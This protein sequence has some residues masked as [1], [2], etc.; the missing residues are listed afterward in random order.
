MNLFKNLIHYTPKENLTELLKRIRRYCGK[1]NDDSP[2]IWGLGLLDG[3]S[4]EKSQWIERQKTNYTEIDFTDVEFYDEDNLWDIEVYL[5]GKIEGTEFSKNEM[6]HKDRA[7]LNGIIRKTKPKTIVEIGVSAGGS[8]CVI[9]NAIRDMENS[10]LYS[11]DY[12]TIWYRDNGQDNG[13]KTGFLVNKIVPEYVSKWE[14]YTGGVPCKYF[15]EHLPNEG[16]DI[17]FIDTA[18]FNPGEHLN[19]LEILPFM[20]KNGII[21]YHDTA[22]HSLSNPNGTTNLVSINT[23]NGKRILLDSNQTMGL[24]NIGAII[25]T[26]NMETKLFSLFSNLS[27]PWYCNITDDDFVEMYKYFSK[28]YSNDL[29][30]I[31]IYYCYFYMNGGLQ[32]KI[33]AAQIAEKETTN[34]K[35]EVINYNNL[36]NESIN[37]ARI[38]H[39]HFNDKFANPTIS[40]INKHFPKDEHLHLVYR[41]FDYV[42]TA[43]EFPSGKNVFEIKYEMINPD[44]LRNKKL[45][46]HSL[47]H[48]ENVKLLY[49]N[50]NL[51]NN[52]YWM[53]WGGDL[54]NAP[55]DIYNEYVR[56]NIYGIG[57]FCD[58]EITREKYG[59]NHKYFNTNLVYPPMGRNEIIRVTVK[60]I[61]KKRNIVIQINNSAD[62]TTIEMLDILSKFKNEN[63]EIRTVLS[64]GH[65][66]FNK[67]IIKK[68]KRIF[69]EKFSYIK[70]M[71]EPYEYLN[72]FAENDI[73]IL[74]HNRQQGGGNA[75][76]TLMMG[77][78]LYIKSEVTTKKWL[79]D[80][81]FNV[82]DSNN[83]SNMDFKEFIF[84]SNEDAKNNIKLSE[85]MFGESNYVNMFREVF[86]DDCFNHR[87]NTK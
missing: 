9:L 86:D 29:V 78:K 13:R 11:F 64:Y 30:R 3:I 50:K 16:V 39:F 73:L 59:G 61:E 62:K 58:I 6:S 17:C 41:V 7:F 46:F 51:L 19:I 31:Y 26:E 10:K 75:V 48:Q 1:I 20:K 22:Y 80:S 47:F 23:L 83:I 12:S 14:L 18:H 57:S 84:F 60:N 40:F 25:L 35:S 68:G 21:V 72:K 2:T 42:H 36:L 85:K 56:N 66:K 67:K 4:I 38:I 70:E 76:M 43:Q 65:T 27:L 5:H 63:I 87:N 28:Y 52:S 53:I 44:F 69:K 32:N 79:T 37:K 54:Y 24:P 45:I 74:Y 15:D 8:T 49:E 82:F 77:K 55:N 33:Q 81:G 71:L 34:W